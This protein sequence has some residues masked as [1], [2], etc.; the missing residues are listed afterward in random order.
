MVFLA[1]LDADSRAAFVEARATNPYLQDRRA[2]G[3]QTLSVPP[4]DNELLAPASAFMAQKLQSKRQV[5]ANLPVMMV[6]TGLTPSQ[7]IEYAMNSPFPLDATLETA[8][9]NNQIYK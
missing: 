2:Q 1:T 5:G 9:I 6:P 8:Q 7:H 3:L 4:D